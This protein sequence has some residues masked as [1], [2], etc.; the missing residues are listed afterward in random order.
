MKK[1]TLIF[2]SLVIVLTMF[3]TS[4]FAWRSVRTGQKNFERAWSAY[5]FKRHEKAK[6]HYIK[7]AN[8]FGE[9][10]AEKPPSRTTMFA[11]NL[12]L[13]GMSLYNA[14]RYEETIDAMKKATSK[15]RRLWEAPLY[16]AL[17]QA[18]LGDKAKTIEALHAYIK[19]SP[20][21]AILSNEV[22]KQLTD[23]ETDSGTLESA[24]KKIEAAIFTQFSQN[25]TLNGRS[26]PDE[27]GLCNG[28]YWWRYNKAPCSE[29]QFIDD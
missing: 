16:T 6:E 3:A 20:G 21:Q 10:L 4:A 11:S 14:D 25:V 27:N 17:S 8:A 23:L 7:A 26:A 15:D 22:N 13:A 12:T 1:Q 9:A 19:T 29:K 2:I 5:L 18:Q 28:R 24:V